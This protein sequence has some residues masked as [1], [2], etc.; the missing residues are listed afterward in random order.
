M[1]QGP[2]VRINPW[3]LHICD[4]EF[5][6]TIYPWTR[7][8]KSSQHLRFFDAPSSIVATPDRDLHHQRRAAAEPSFNKASVRTF[9]PHIQ[10]AVD[11]V[12]ARLDKEYSGREAVA[13]LSDVF[14]CYGG[15][16]VAEF[17]FSWDGEFLS[18]P[19]FKAPLLTAFDEFMLYTHYIFHFG[20][21][22]PLFNFIPDKLLPATAQTVHQFQE[23]IRCCIKDLQ[24]ETRKADV[25]TGHKPVMETLLNSKLPAQEKTLERLNHEG[26]IMFA[27]GQS[28]PRV[29][30]TAMFHLL[31]QPAT[32]QRLRDEI[33]NVF[34]DQTVP[35]SLPQ[36][37]KLPFLTAVI[38]EGGF[39]L[40]HNSTSSLSAS[41][42][43]S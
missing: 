13:T 20:F 39:L 10:A 37:E 25:N 7:H 40:L 36:L 27:A 1:R 43:V 17:C 11:T 2:V 14:A 8:D 26:Y 4:P 23:A 22:L 38:M 9:V 28:T 16:V 29:L 21:L 6:K 12:I 5:F 15:H 18:S 41:G 3:E 24:S 34:P 42:L 33:L 32:M 30:T 35:P 19:K 31:Q